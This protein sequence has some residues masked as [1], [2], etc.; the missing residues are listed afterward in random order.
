M[1]LCWGIP[2]NS[3][4]AFTINQLKS[5]FQWI[6]Q[7]SQIGRSAILRNFHGECGEFVTK[8]TFRYGKLGNS[9]G[10]CDEIVAMPESEPRITH[11]IHEVH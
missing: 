8:L 7:F 6:N 2:G 5:G 4:K 11:I 10:A 1:I 9:G 3:E